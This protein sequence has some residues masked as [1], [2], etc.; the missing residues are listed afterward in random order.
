LNPDEVTVPTEQ[1]LALEGRRMLV[2]HIRAARRKARH[3]AE[4]ELIGLLHGLGALAEKG[5]PLSDQRGVFWVSVPAT[6]VSAVRA[7]LPQLGYCDAVDLVVPEDETN[8][9][10]EDSVIGSTRWRR[11][12]YQLIRIYQEDAEALRERAPDRRAFVFERSD[13]EVRAIRGYRG[14]NDPLT[15]RALPVADARLLV[16]LLAASSPGLLLDPFA[17]AGGIVL[18]AVAAGWQVVSADVDPAVRHGLSADG[19]MHLVADARQ[20]PIA[21]GTVAAIATEPPYDPSI[22]T[23]AA[24]CLTELVRVLRPGGQLAMFCAAWQ[25]DTVRKAALATG[26]TPGLDTPVDRKGVDVVVFV[27]RR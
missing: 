5:G 17:G 12:P 23:L 14:S 19:A 11:Q 24:D 10:P 20:L 21:A 8:A 1:R 6:S 9:F 16:N 3:A 27:L 18:E 2:C 7:R 15:H 26:L 4:G 22:G 13:G 25:A